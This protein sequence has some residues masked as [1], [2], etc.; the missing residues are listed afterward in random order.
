MATIAVFVA[1]GGASYA[2]LQLPKKSVG[3]RQLKGKAVTAPKIRKSAV[4][5]A[6]IKD[7]AVTGAKVADG[8]LSGNDLADGTMT[9]VKVADGSLSGIDIDQSSLTAVRASNVIGVALNADCSPATPFPAGVSASADAGACVV[10]F[11]SS[12]LSCAASA[13]VGFRTSLALKPAERSVYTLRN[14]SMPDK[15]TTVPYNA[16]T[17]TALPVDLTLVC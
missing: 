10:T 11:G 8:S 6:K 1:I 13:A 5:R 17:Q 3:A 16:G 2:S 14:P 15:L 4:T 12:V 7:N 9:G